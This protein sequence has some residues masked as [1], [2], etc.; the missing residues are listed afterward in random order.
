MSQKQR[1]IYR[2][3]L[4]GFLIIVLSVM[5]VYWYWGVQR[6]VP[7]EIMIYE[8]QLENINLEIPF[9]KVRL[10][11]EDVESTQ[12]SVNRS[13]KVNGQIQFSMSE[14]VSIKAAKCGSVSGEAKLFGWLPCKKI[15]I[16]VR[17]EARVM[18]VGSAVGL[19][20][21][22]DG[23]MVLGTGKVSGKN[24]ATYTPSYDILQTGDY[25][26]EVNGTS[27]L[28]I[29]DIIRLIQKNGAGRL[30]LSVNRGSRQIKVKLKPVQADDG[31]YQIGVW[32]RED[33]EGIGT[34]TFVTEQNEFAAL[35]HG[36]TD[37]DTELLIR[38]QNGGLYPAS[39]DH[40]VAGKNGSPGELTG[41]VELGNQNRL[42]TIRNNTELGITG[43]VTSEKY[44]YR[45]D[46]AYRIGRKQEVQ[47]GKATI[48]CQL[49][50]RVR[51]YEVEIEE[52]NLSSEDNKGIEIHV[53]DPRLLEQAGGIVQGMSGAPL[54]QNG[55]C[56]GAVTHV[57]VKDVTRGYATFI[58]NML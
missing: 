50:D 20:V 29:Q 36:I 39:I 8:N 16:D 26:Y 51:E 2:I 48:M 21:H 34:L 43:D 32:L 35:G 9:T 56:I 55:K 22:A 47:K 33:T 37:A 58:E 24:G 17:E 1:Q 53:T 27:V 54:I 49:D 7:D 4:L 30:V 31:S 14:S 13:E 11:S 19:Y 42:G 46:K 12:V 28:T 57:F 40:V 10:S 23:V 38:L 25:I 6:M 15:R 44:K 45:E 52:I 41:R 5:V 18:P 3:C